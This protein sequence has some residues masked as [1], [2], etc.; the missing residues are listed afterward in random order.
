MGEDFVNGT[1]WTWIAGPLRPYSVESVVLTSTIC[2]HAQPLGTYVA[3]T[4]RHLVVVPSLE[5]QTLPVA[6]TLEKRPSSA[7]F[8]DVVRCSFERKYLAEL[9]AGIYIALS[10]RGAF[11]MPSCPCDLMLV[12]CGRKDGAR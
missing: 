4:H 8:S 2:S 5:A 6:L 7:A 9:S 11:P 10:E 12:S 1:T 3:S